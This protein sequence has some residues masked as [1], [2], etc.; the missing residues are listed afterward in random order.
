MRLT[1]PVLILVA[2]AA[3]TPQTMTYSEA[4][5]HCQGEARKA[6][7]PTGE[8]SVGIGTGGTS[9]GLSVEISDKWI[10]GLD[11]EVVYNQ[12]LD[13]LRAQGRISGEI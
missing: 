1:I 12:C 11:P 2:A 3:C 5:E 13:D 10:R 4:V 9:F 8:A 6:A 7:G